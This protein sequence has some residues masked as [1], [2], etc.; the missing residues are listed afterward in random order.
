MSWRTFTDYLKHKPWA[1]RLADRLGRGRGR[2]RMRW[3][4]ALNPPPPARKK[5][6][7]SNWQNLPLAAAWVGHATVL[8]R[9]SGM[10]ILTDPV[11]S[12]RVGL[13]LGLMTAGPRRQVAAALRIDELPPVD[14]ILISHA[15]FDHLDRPTLSRLP[16][17]SPVVT[18]AGT[19]D[20][21]ADL[22]F[23]SVTELPWGEST[24]IGDGA[25]KVTAQ[26]VRH[27]GARTFYDKH[28]GY[29][30]Y[31][32][33]AGGVRVLYGGDSAYQDFFRQVANVDLA[34]LGIGAYDPYI[35][36]HATPE[37]AWEMAGHA[38]AAAVM[39]MHHST[40]RLSHEPMDEPIR[41]MLAA[42]G[43]DSARVVVREIGDMWWKSK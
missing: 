19:S 5:P 22:G 43:A 28:R 2:G 17:G 33:E 20:L 37:Q 38:G 9:I 41:R 26:E 23:A 8:L 12:H 31:L 10:T 4:D 29:N 32:L 25:L 30:G 39:P 24:T 42:A 36:A 18:A 40:F 14:L 21:I 35:Q 7:L 34:I 3:L 6:D 27:W 13:G 16:K 1:L 11:F 15:H